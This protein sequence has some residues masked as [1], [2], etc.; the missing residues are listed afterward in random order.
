[1]LEDYLGPRKIAINNIDIHL[2]S[3]PLDR[4]HQVF[5]L[6]DYENSLLESVSPSIINKMPTIQLNTSTTEEKK[7]NNQPPT[8]TDQ[9]IAALL[10]ADLAENKKLTISSLQYFQNM[11]PRIAAIKEII[12]GKNTLHSYILKKGIVCKLFKENS[13]QPARETIYIPTVLLAPIIIYI[14]K[15]FLH[16]STSQTY[17][18]FTS[19]YFHPQAR[20]TV[21]KICKACITCSMTRNAEYKNVPVGT[22]RSFN[23]TKPRQAISADII[24]MPKSSKGYTHA[25]MIADLYS[26]YLSFI[27]L[28]SKSSEATAAAFRQ[29]FTFMGIP[30]IVYTDNDQTF[31]GDVSTL[32]TSFQIQHRTSFPYMQRGNTVESQVR[33][34]LN[35]A[36]AAIEESHIAK[37]SEWHI[38]YPLVII[39]LNTLISKYGLSKEYVHFQQISDSHLPLI[40]DIKL[41]EEIESNLS[42]TSH[43]FRGAI[44]K[45]LKNKEKSKLRYPN[46]KEYHF[47][48]HELVMRKN[49]TPDNSLKTTFLGPFRIMNLY[50]QGALLKD[51]RTGEEMSAHFANLR[52]ITMSEFAQ[53]L[54]THFDADILKTLQFSRYN[55]QGQPEEIQKCTESQILQQEDTCEPDTGEELGRERPA[56]Q[57]SPPPQEAGHERPASK[58]NSSASDL[59]EFPEN[60]QRILRSGKKIK[61]NT[62][63][64]P[65]KYDNATSAQWTKLSPPHTPVHNSPKPIRKRI[66]TL[67][68]P[69]TPYYQ[70][71]QKYGE[72]V[73]FFATSIETKLCHIKPERN[74]KTRYRSSF[75]SD[76]KG[77]L[78]INL[79]EEETT[80]ERVRFSRIEI[81]FY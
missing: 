28:K 74:F 12:I 26:L 34:F 55:R 54:P 78:Y 15:H 73:Y 63:T 17:I 50:E 70:Q 71:E 62:S 72:N 48:L 66:T 46:K 31:R 43:K 42:Q 1:M 65:P 32:L 37:H 19:L 60:I 3:S 30:E 79:P 75:N 8:I 64:L 59:K 27:P 16:P 29:Y 47:A 24:Y 2:L 40:L 58:E 9:E 67:K 11:D 7:P 10:A 33:K 36:R 80:A 4:T 25:L 53:L 52:K 77:I 6:Q 41:D 44:Q 21:Q 68:T 49:Y 5:E 38:L 61:I 22:A 20:R 35:A 14:H 56:L 23:P 18:Q 69:N 13:T 39:R 51:P 57:E 81:K 45:F 76:R